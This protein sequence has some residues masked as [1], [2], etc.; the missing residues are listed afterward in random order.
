MKILISSK[1]L[2]PNSKINTHV[3]HNAIFHNR[4]LKVCML[5]AT[6]SDTQKT[7]ERQSSRISVVSDENYLKRIR[8]L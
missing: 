5:S 7:A 3:C 4:T 1:A 6:G 2:L 8:K